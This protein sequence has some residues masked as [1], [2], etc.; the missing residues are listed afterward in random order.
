MSQMADPSFGVH[1]DLL[2][3]IHLVSTYRYPVKATIQPNEVTSLLM[4]APKI[5]R[6]TAPFYW[7]YID[8]PENG[9]IFL[10]WQP[11]QQMN[12]Q[13]ASDGYVWPPQE[14]YYQQEVG[15]GVILEM[16]LQKAGFAYG[17]QYAMHSR[18]RFRLIP[19]NVPNP[20]APQVDPSLWI[21]HYGP[22]EPNDR[23]H[24]SQLPRDN[25]TQ[26]IHETR[27]YLYRCGQI[28]RKEFILGDR[29]NWPQIGWPREAPRQPVY[30]GN[31][32]VPQSMAYPSQA[33]TPS[34]PPSKRARTSQAAHAQGAPP[35][36]AL[37]HQDSAYDDDEDTS[38]GD[39]FDHLTP[40]E[41]SL[42]RYRQNHEWM[43]EILSSPYSLG[44]IGFADIGLGLKGELSGLT[45]GIF[46]SQD[47]KTLVQPSTAE[48]KTRLD[49]EQAAE[50]RKRVNDRIASTNSEIEKMKAEHARK[51]A[52]FKNNSILTKSE[53]ELRSTTDGTSR[54]GFNLEGRPDEH[55]EVPGR[56]QNKTTKTVDAIIASVESQLGRHA[57][58]VNELRRIQA[59]G[60]QEPAPEPVPEPEPTPAVPAAESMTVGGGTSGSNAMSRQAS[61]A[62]SNHSGIMIGDSDIDMGGTAAGLLDQ[63]YTGMSSTST[64]NNFPTPQAHLSAAQSNA[65]TPVNVASPQAAPQQAG[66]TEAADVKMGD[67]E[68]PKGNDVTAGTV[69]DQGSG[70]GDWV[71]VPK[72]G[73]TPGSNGTG[74]GTGNNENNAGDSEPPKPAAANPALSSQQAS[75]V[76]TPA[77]ASTGDFVDFG[78]LGDLDT[79]GDALA[80]YTPGDMTADLDLG[81]DM[82]I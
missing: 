7:T 73:A 25:R 15:N 3:H 62:G 60:Y 34:G 78:S 71:V 77:G 58:A 42:H 52:R 38:R 80:G 81:T 6:D 11:L 63:M 1:R 22:N 74:A 23:I 69:P 35:M 50:F 33:P 26:Q 2:P 8:K 9:S 17:D 24:A 14:T 57:Q 39:M 47:Y 41:I 29:A 51:L 28:Q 27:S 46:E 61:Q 49:P 54:D 68:A 66:A 31:R 10:T 30:A 37:S 53:K 82:D 5:A 19:P 18:R 21:V 67:S 72:D 43:E 16:Y 45:E 4:Q 40:R 12:V 56:W 79:A 32:G 55:G 13:L 75:A 64:P 44:Q 36:G 70:S 48:A 59:G 20:N 76:G 65:A